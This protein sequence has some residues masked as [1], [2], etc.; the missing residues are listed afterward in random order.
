M[1]VN[2]FEKTGLLI[3][4]LIYSVTLS[5][6]ESIAPNVSDWISSFHLNIDDHF[7]EVKNDTLSRYSRTY[8]LTFCDG[9]LVYNKTN[10]ADFVKTSFN[11]E[12]ELHYQFWH[13]AKT[14][15]QCYM[16]T[17]NG[18]YPEGNIETWVAVD[19]VYTDLRGNYNP[20]APTANA[21]RIERTNN[22]S[23][24][25]WK[26]LT[27]S[28]KDSCFCPITNCKSKIHHSCI[29]EEVEEHYIKR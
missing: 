13:T 3:L 12:D 20:E 9:E 6:Q 17:Q 19:G 28:N 1:M 26:I 4:L 29:L 2:I 27:I 11:F 18:H 16:Y 5:A 14:L 10:N 25:K 8:F 21:F 24:V 15:E 7:C 23:I 22:R